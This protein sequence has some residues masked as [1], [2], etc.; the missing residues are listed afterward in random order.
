VSGRRVKYTEAEAREAIAASFSWAESLRQLGLCSTGGAWRVLRKYAELWAIPTDHFLP[1]GRPPVHGR[2][3]DELL[4]EHSPVRGT[5]IKERLYRE[6]LKQRS[7]Q[8]C[9]Q[10]E[11]WN[12]S[13]MALILD[14]INGVRDDNRIENLRIVCPN[15]NAGLDT[16]C[17]RAARIVRE[18][19]MCE[20]CAVEYVPK[21]GKQRFCSQYCGSRH[22]NRPQQPRAVERPPLEDLLSGVLTVGYEAIGREHGVSGTAV[23]K[24]IRS[25]GI[26]P[27]PGRGRH[28]GPAPIVELRLVA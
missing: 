22:A 10:G 26:E 23:R 7:C 2:S 13:R 16:H 9:G 17:G 24:W 18:S 19:R 15:C 25:Y 5:K 11:E 8:L 3:L 28:A 1:N 20:R 6:G 4:V 27:P 14:H 12:G 21:Y